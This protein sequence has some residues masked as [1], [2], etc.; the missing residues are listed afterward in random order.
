MHQARRR[1]AIVALAT[2]AATLACVGGA[3][4][5]S[6][7]TS[8]TGSGGTGTGASATTPDCPGKQLGRRTLRLGDCGRDVATLNWIL[9]AKDYGRPA[10]VGRFEEA[11]EVA[12][13]AFQRDA[14]LG[15][16]GVLDPETSDV[17]INAMPPQLA[18]WYGP[19]FFGNQTACGETLTTRTRGVAHRT[20]PCG[21]KVVLNYNGRFVRT[22]VIDRGPFANGAKWDLTQA[23][24]QALRF[25]YTDEVRVA[26]IAAS[27][28]DR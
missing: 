1:K 11:T 9:K 4:A 7:G 13:E 24:A 20:L 2:L 12:V 22:T 27:A 8:A 26:K 16:D 14:D 18:T 19:G 10:L 5:S 3:Q 25:E 15:V 23:T 17:L 28:V 21:S 6:G